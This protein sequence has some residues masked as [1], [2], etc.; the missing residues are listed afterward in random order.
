MSQFDP[1]SEFTHVKREVAQAFEE[2]LPL[3][4]NKTDVVVNRVWVDDTKESS[5]VRDQR[6]AILGGRSW[7]VPIRADLTLR[8]DGKELR[9]VLQRVLYVRCDAVG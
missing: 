2:A 5:D 8:R 6:R 4:T 7:Q 3:S 9:E 1:E